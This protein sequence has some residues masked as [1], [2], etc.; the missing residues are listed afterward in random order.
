MQARGAAWQHWR[1]WGV[2]LVLFVA[3]CTSAPASGMPTASKPTQATPI[4]RYQGHTGPVYTVA[5]SPDGTR[6]ASGSDDSTVQ[7][8]D[9][10]SGRLFL[11]Y[12][13]HTAGVR[14]LAWSPDGTLIASASQDGTV[15]VWDA[16]SGHPLLT[17]QGQARPVWAVA[18]APGGACLAS[19]TG[20]TSA[21]QQQE[22]VQVWDAATGHRRSLYPVPSGAVGE[23]ADGTFSLAWSP[24]GKQLASGGADTLV[25]LWQAP[26]CQG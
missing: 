25:H 15:Q 19:A 3:A 5:W 17:Y 26:S 10:Q 16:G 4:T 24:D 9:A 12:R 14:Q 1:W 11:T 21:E 18:W 20:N 6:I 8:W 23:L 7:I 13:G 2:G 22:T